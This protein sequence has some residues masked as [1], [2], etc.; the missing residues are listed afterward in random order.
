MKRTVK[1]LVEYLSH[2]ITL[3]TYRSFVILFIPRKREWDLSS[4]A[5]SA[6]DLVR[7]LQKENFDLCD[8]EKKRV[9]DE[10]EREG[11][12]DEQT[13]QKQREE[14]D[15]V[16]YYKVTSTRV[17]EFIVFKPLRLIKIFGD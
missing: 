10:R 7:E 8:K 3:I 2:S 9:Q 17:L 4:E 14:N 1:Y 11:D 6:G 13:F 5:E 15:D 12:L 16:S